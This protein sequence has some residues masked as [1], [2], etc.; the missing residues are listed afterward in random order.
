MIIPGPL[1]YEEESPIARS[2]TFFLFLKLSRSLN[3]GFEKIS[4][5]LIASLVPCPALLLLAIFEIPKEWGHR[6]QR[7]G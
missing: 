6:R 2:F 1:G 3:I 5:F 4:S 7:K